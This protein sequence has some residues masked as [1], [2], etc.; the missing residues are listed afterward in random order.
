MMMCAAAVELVV[1]A[2]EMPHRRVP[3]ADGSVRMSA[4]K[5][6]AVRAAVAPMAAK[7]KQLEEDAYRLA[8]R[9]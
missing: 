7:Q 4:S 2:Q 1:E 5:K 8:G 6:P 9:R 3:L